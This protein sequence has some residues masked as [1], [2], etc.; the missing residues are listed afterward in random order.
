[1]LT[2]LD[3]EAAGRTDYT[4]L[5]SHSSLRPVKNYVSRSNL[6]QQLKCQ[7]LRCLETYKDLVQAMLHYANS[8]KTS[9]IVWLT[10]LDGRSCWVSQ[11]MSSVS[12]FSYGKIV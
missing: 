9:S 3:S 4:G 7:L 11:K 8:V 5:Y 6:H 10:L 1:M 12:S 2:S